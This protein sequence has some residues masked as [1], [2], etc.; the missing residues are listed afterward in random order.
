MTPELAL[1]H[2]YASLFRDLINSKVQSGDRSIV[3]LLKLNAASDWDFLTAAMDIVDDASSAIGHVQ[4][5]GLGG[6]TKYN[7]MGEKYLRLYGL[8]SAA[9]IQQQAILTIYRIMNVPDLK[10]AKGSFDKLDIRTL[11]HKL[12]SHGTDFHDR[13]AGKREAYVPLRLN[14]GDMSVTSV[15]YTGAARQHN[16]DLGK[17]IKEHIELAIG[18]LDRVIEKSMSTLFLAGKKKSEILSG[19]SNLRIEKAGGLVL[20]PQGGPQIIVTFVD[21]AGG[22][23]EPA[24]FPDDEPEATN[25]DGPDG[26]QT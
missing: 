19:L 8:L 17:A 4:A 21:S 26:G 20:G 25:R 24:Y 14:L 13:A 22:T 16:V 23:T 2:K 3:A 7:D 11:R 10:A 5:F 1:L 6:V 12:S 15:N 18:V 9:Y